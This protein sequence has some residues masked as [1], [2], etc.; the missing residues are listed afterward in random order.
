MF[1]HVGVGG[2]VWVYG[3]VYTCR[4]L[5]PALN[6]FL[7]KCLENNPE[8]RPPAQQVPVLST[9]YNVFSLWDD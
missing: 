1:V 6:V 2:G 8:A 5:S 7:N 4:V 3:C 9:E